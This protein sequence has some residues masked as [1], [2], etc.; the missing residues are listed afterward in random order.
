MPNL[1]ENSHASKELFTKEI[2]LSPNYLEKSLEGR[3][4]YGSDTDMES[5][6]EVTLH[7]TNI[8]HNDDLV[9]VSWPSTSPVR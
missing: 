2:D 6:K 3:P 8:S 1:K 5:E 7:W 4:Y 9:I